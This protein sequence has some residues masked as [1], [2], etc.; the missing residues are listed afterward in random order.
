MRTLCRLLIGSLN[1]SQ[2]RWKYKLSKVD[3]KEQKA[4]RRKRSPPLGLGSCLGYTS[5]LVHLLA[6][7]YDRT[8]LRSNFWNYEKLNCKENHIGKRDSS[9]QT[10][11]QVQTDPVTFI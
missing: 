5:I 1:I 8:Y 7:I 11:V 10:N 6:S 3:T 4:S 9:V 2:W